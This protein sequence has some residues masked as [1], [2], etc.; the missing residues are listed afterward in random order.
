VKPT[1]VRWESVV[2]LA[3]MLAI[4][5]NQ[6]PALVAVGALTAQVRADLGLSASAVSLLTT[7]PLLCF[8]AVAAAAAPAS[9]KWGTDRTL[10]VALAVLTVGIA[11]RLLPSIP[12]LF[13]GSAVAGVGI[14]VTNVLLPGVIKRDYPDRVGV[15]M[16]VYSLC[17]NGGAA[18]AAAASVPIGAALHT[19]W[20]VALASWGLLAV[21]ALL[22]WL[23]RA[24][25]PPNSTGPQSNS[26]LRLWRSPLAWAV[27]AFMGLQSLI[28]YA[29][30]AWLPTVFH[31]AGMSQAGGGAMAGVM[32]AVG[33]VTS[34]TVPIVATRLS[35]QR[36]LVLVSVLGFAIGLVGLVTHPLGA[37][38]LWSSLLGLAQGA[39][40]GLALTLFVLRS[41][42]APAASELSGMAQSVGYLVAAAGPF[43]VGV[44]HDATHGWGVP[45]AALLAATAALLT[46][47]WIAGADRSVERDTQGQRAAATSTAGPLGRS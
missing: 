10:V 43:V 26:S 7:L 5:L 3:G 20:R 22:L 12:A 38:I 36:P 29:L 16:G 35:N 42:S 41:R 8:G 2:L 21:L 14:A 18:L 34:L 28:Y 25:P 6:R 32:S 30:V 47:G 4:S 17:L 1:L 39:G 33:M 40:I 15:M 31:D 13:I 24:L 45:V 37:P 46:A 44:L 19:N 9:R 23:P 11:L 27:A